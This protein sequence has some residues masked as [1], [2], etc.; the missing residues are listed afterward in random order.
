MH[1]P[2]FNHLPVGEKVR[3]RRVLGYLV[4][5][6]GNQAV[7][8]AENGLPYVIPETLMGLSAVER[9]HDGP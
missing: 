7:G 6:L 1:R 3:M 2:Q 9:L 4:L 8:E 5:T